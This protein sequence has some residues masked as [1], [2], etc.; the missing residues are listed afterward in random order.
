M[1]N[2][3][4]FP[5]TDTSY[6]HRN[7]HGLLT[8]GLPDN[9]WENFV[10]KTSTSPTARLPPNASLS[11]NA[12]LLPKSSDKRIQEILCSLPHQ[13]SSS[14]RRRRR[15]SCTG[16]LPRFPRLQRFPRLPRFRLP[17]RFNF[18]RAPVPSNSSVDSDDLYS[19]K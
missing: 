11:P 5:H 3:P 14:T 1:I 15:K 13:N 18:F 17:P 12:G 8:Y 7:A 9:A 19:S 10:E 4:S 6:V 16:R 2:M